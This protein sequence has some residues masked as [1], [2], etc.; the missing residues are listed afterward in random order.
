MPN[1]TK[2]IKVLEMVRPYLLRPENDFTWSFWKDQKQAIG[3]INQFITTLQEGQAFNELS[4]SLLFAP[5]GPI[6]EVSISSGWGDV[7]LKLADQFD[8]A[9]E[10]EE[11]L[12]SDQNP[13][14]CLTSKDSNLIVIQELGMD[15]N[16]AEVSILECEECKRLWLRY[17]YEIEAFSNSGRW[18]L[19]NISS[20]DR[21]TLMATNAKAS[22]EKLGWY[23]CGGSYYDG[24]VSRSAGPIRL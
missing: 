24:K 15:S 8:E 11:F 14:A 6:Q 4:L 12:P 18:Y 3:E 19:G 20:E 22:L 5:T 2:L 7:F 17:F 1:K 13:C 16:F 10:S 23:F 9:M 21:E